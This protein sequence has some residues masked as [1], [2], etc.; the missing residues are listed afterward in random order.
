MRS[1]TTSAN[2][3]SPAEC[4]R[5]DADALLPCSAVFFG[6]YLADTDLRADRTTRLCAVAAELV[7]FLY[8]EASAKAWPPMGLAGLQYFMPACQGKL[9]LAW[10]YVK[11]WQ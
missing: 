9:K 4:E 7:E 2:D 8:V 1:A 5:R 10:K 3:P 6:F 11:V